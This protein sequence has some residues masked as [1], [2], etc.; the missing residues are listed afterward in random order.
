MSYTDKLIPYYLKFNQYI[1]IGWR[2]LWVYLFNVKELKVNSNDKT[3]SVMWRYFFYNQLTG[4]I[5]FFTFLRNKIDIN[6]DKVHVTKMTMDGDKT[7]ILEKNQNNDL[8]LE[9]VDQ[10][11]HDIKPDEAMLGCVFITF[12]LVNSENEKVCLKEYMIKYKDFDEKH[13]HTLENI[14][15]FNDIPY[16]EDSKILIRVAKNRKIST[17]ELRLREVNDKHINYFTNL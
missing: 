9:H 12:D 5:S 7:I 16:S 6:F 14:F 8:T 17:H 13:S 11:M 3:Y 4:I 15:I 10:I 1:S 2:L